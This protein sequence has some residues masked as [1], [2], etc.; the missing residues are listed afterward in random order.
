MLR[1]TTFTN[2]GG[3]VLNTIRSALKPRSTFVDNMSRGPMPDPGRGQ[4]G[5][6]NGAPPPKPPPPK[7]ERTERQKLDTVPA[8]HAQP[9]VLEPRSSIKRT[10]S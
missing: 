6:P 3:S 9:V 2:K 4:P 7:K 1:R 5:V 8:L 10:D